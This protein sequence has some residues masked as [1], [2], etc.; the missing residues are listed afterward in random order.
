MSTNYGI[1]TVN[2]MGD[3]QFPKVSPHPWTPMLKT[4]FIFTRSCQHSPLTILEHFY[5]LGS[6]A[7]P[8]R[9]PT[10]ATSFPPSSKRFTPK[11]FQHSCHRDSNLKPPPKSL[12]HRPSIPAKNLQLQNPAQPQPSLTKSLESSSRRGLEVSRTLDFRISINMHHQP[13]PH[14]SHP[15]SS[16]S[17]TCKFPS[18][19]PP[20][21]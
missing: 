13:L 18:S 4:F 1:D 15:K 19:P 6:R 5:Q 12:P 8:P 14:R 17:Q 11:M 10:L 20:T 16:L 9:S 7:P 2:L 3:P 21:L